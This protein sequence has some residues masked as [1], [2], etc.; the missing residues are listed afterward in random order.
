MIIYKILLK[1]IKNKAYENCNNNK[2][3][4]KT[5]MPA[6]IGGL[7]RLRRVMRDVISLSRY[8]RF[9]GLWRKGLLHGGC[10]GLM[11]QCKGI[12]SWKD[13]IIKWFNIIDILFGADIQLIRIMGDLVPDPTEMLQFYICIFPARDKVSAVKSV[14]FHIFYVKADAAAIRFA[15]ATDGLR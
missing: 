9:V 7:F 11:K 12:L 3:P 5:A 10:P 2:S 14:S 15:T 13:R 8:I 4:E 1:V 6:S